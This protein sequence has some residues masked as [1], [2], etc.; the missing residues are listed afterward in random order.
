[1]AIIDDED[2]RGI[3]SKA[4]GQLARL[5]MVIHSLQMQ[6]LF[7]KMMNN[8]VNSAKVVLDYLIVHHSGTEG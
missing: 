8:S 2:H 1:M 4:K 3:L 5:A 7:L 6:L